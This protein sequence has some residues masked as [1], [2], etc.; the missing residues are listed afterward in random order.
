MA[1]TDYATLQSTVQDYADNSATLTAARVQ[2]AIQMAEGEINQML[3]QGLEA[4]RKIRPMVTRSDITVDAEFETI[5]TTPAELALPISLEITSITDQPWRI[6][7]VDPD[8]LVEMK[9]R[10]ELVRSELEQLLNVANAPPK[11]YTIVGTEFRFFPEP[12]TSYTVEYT[13]YSRLPALSDSNTTNWLLT[14]FPNVYLYASLAQAM[15]L[16]VDQT[17]TKWDAAFQR[18]IA[19]VLDAYPV[20][21][22]GARLRSY[23]MPLGRRTFC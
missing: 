5:P 17:D 18:A 16:D 14:A 3:T 2:T 10:E 6:T 1:I 13:R 23:D 15:A 8:A 22:S 21:T 11:H 9:Q 19:A 20:P 4:G 12:E 7:Y